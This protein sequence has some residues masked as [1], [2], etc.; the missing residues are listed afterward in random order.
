[1]SSLSAALRDSSVIA[2]RNLRNVIRTPGAMVTSVAQP[3]M[4]V[5]LL[6][7]VF[8]GTLGGAEYRTFLIGGILAQTLTFNASFT[9]VYLAKDLQLGLI[10]RFRSLPM[11]RGAV[12]LGRSSAD[13]VTSLLSIA[14]TLLCGLAI[15]W[16]MTNGLGPA[17]IAMGLLLLFTFAVSWV[18]AVIAL[19]ARSVEV[20][21][22]LGLIWLFPVTFISGAFVSVQSMPGP[23]RTF[24]EWNPVTAV[25]TSVRE[26]FGNAEP[27]GFAPPSGWPA[28]NAL[29][30]AV[31]CC[32]S[33]IAIFAPLAIS[34]YVRISKR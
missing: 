4:F 20:A 2:G 1:M 29:L 21:Q 34:Q 18:G 11:S 5:L 7:F 25:A 22:S 17:L 31:L 12:I 16:R 9:A 3:I 23:L 28:D 30:Y 8:G 13:L 24:A 26:L 33:I 15:G 14:V 32:V 6:A 27:Q 19:T 10:D